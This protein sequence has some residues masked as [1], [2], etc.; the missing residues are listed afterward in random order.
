MTRVPGR[1]PE[2]TRG[3]DRTAY[4]GIR[5]ATCRRCWLA[6][7]MENPTLNNR[8]VR[9]EGALNARDL[10][11]LPTTTGVTETGRVFRMARPEGLT[12]AGWRRAYDEGVRTIVDLRNAEERP[13]RPTDPVVSDAL[14]ARFFVI[15][16]PTEDCSDP[17][18]L[19]V[20]A[21]VLNSPESYRD[22]LRLWPEKF[23][24]VF[25][26]IALSDGAVV[27]HCSAGRDRTG[28]VTMVL[29]SLA[30]AAPEVIADDYELAVRAFDEHAR[31]VLQPRESLP[32]WELRTADELERWV[33]HTRAE[34][35]KA[36]EGFD[37]AG[38]LL[39]AGLTKGEVGALR[40]RLL[41]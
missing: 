2:V 1:R 11:G 36:L 22:N 17:E 12:E 8:T 30:G 7:R 3:R 38:Y 20:C 5:I 14:L 13:R 16:A 6:G 29:L 39:Q 37:A 28:M 21:P 4:Q 35:I 24:T 23:A 18:F 10:G 41:A 33:A 40:A 32:G 31:L 25:R 19:R 15:S 9:W 26:A 27:V 34:L